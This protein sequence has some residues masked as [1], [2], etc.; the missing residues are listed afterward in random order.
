MQAV[1]TKKLE[2][3]SPEMR[4]WLLD[5]AAHSR[6]LADVVKALREHGMEVSLSTLTRFV[7]EHREKVLI[8]EGEG[9]KTAVD[10]LANRG[11]GEA[12]RKGTLEAVRQRLYEDAL[13]ATNSTTRKMYA[14][15]LKEEAKL[16]ELDLAERKLALAAEQ[17]RLQKVRLRLAARTMNGRK[18]VKLD[19]AEVVQEVEGA[20]GDVKR[21]GTGKDAG[22]ANGNA[23]GDGERA[24]GKSREPAG[25]ETCAT[26]EEG[27]D[28]ARAEERV[29][30]LV[31]V[32]ARVE[33][34]LNRG[35]AVE[36]R[37]LEARAVV[38]EERRCWENVE[39]LQMTND[40]GNPNAE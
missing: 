29:T 7:R 37:L 30:G 14:E 23:A 2:S 20:E 34:I 40:K 5:M 8:E 12:L 25:R 11:R 17:L 4:E 18:R 9:M 21:I 16:K 33:E 28:R 26:R 31:G 22:A 6:R 32:M 39:Q 15:L 13:S 24:T 3:L 27:L 1:I 35:G 38:A 19:A 36:E 10:A